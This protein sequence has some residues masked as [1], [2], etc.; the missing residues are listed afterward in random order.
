MFRRCVSLLVLLGFI[1]GQLATVPHAHGANCHSGGHEHDSRLHFHL[2]GHDHPHRHDQGG[3]HGAVPG[4]SFPVPGGST[5]KQDHDA[6]AIYLADGAAIALA[7][8]HESA[9]G[10]A[11]FVSAEVPGKVWQFDGG[12]AAPFHPPDSL[13]AVGKL[14]LT[15]RTLRI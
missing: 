14:F 12:A 7:A 15:L 3:R 5:G 2:G 13:P 6:D 4:E 1:A 8:G 11:T 9:G 10:A